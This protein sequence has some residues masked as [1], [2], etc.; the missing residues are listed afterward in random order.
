MAIGMLLDFPSFGQ[1]DYMSIHRAIG[2]E[3][4]PPDGLLL[5]SAGSTGNG[6]RIFDIW[7]SRQAFERFARERIGPAAERAGLQ[8]QVEPQF[9]ELYNLW[10]PRADEL[11]QL[12]ASPY[13]TA[14]ATA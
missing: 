8:V 10:A 4:E 12:G 9:V 1:D 2:L 13:P 14:A 11:M 5:H 6:W 7:E 3:T